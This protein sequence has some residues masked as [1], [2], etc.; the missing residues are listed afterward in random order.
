MVLLLDPHTL[1][2][3]DRLVQA[4]GPA[5]PIEGATG[6]FVDDLHDA[7]VDEVVLVAVKQFLGAQRLTELVDVVGRDG[8]VEVGDAQELLDLL[9]PRFG[10]HDGLLLLVDFVVGVAGE[11][12][13]DRGELV[14]ELGH[15][16]GRTRDDQRCTGLV[17]E[18]RVDLVDDGVMVTTLDHVFLASGHVVAQV[19]ETELSVRAVGHVAL[20][21][22]A[23]LI[24]FGQVGAD[25]T[26]AESKKT[27]QRA[28]PVGVAR[29]QV[30][31]HRHHVHAI[32]L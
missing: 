6:E 7:T 11:R 26:D 5:S 21:R 30:V 14:V 10:G 20:I 24:K 17:D 13:D 28:H 9:D 18:D 16:R 32:S 19:V 29:R 3:L 25:P 23:L 4:V 12:A 8:V 2:G 1:L 27:V 31:V 15:V 22:L